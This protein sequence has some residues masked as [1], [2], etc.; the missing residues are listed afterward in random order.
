MVDSIIFPLLQMRKLRQCPKYTQLVREEFEPK[1]S[2]FYTVI[3]NIIVISK[4]NDTE[5]SPVPPLNSGGN[6]LS[7]NSP[8][9]LVLL[10]CILSLCFIPRL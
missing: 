3:F 5:R 9:I 8:Q 1:L 7:L 2:D 4:T 6:T 10:M